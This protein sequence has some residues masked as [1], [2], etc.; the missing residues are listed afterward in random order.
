VKLLVDTDVLIDMALD[1]EP[2]A[3][4]AHCR[5]TDDHLCFT[6]ENSLADPSPIGPE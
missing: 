5:A 1:R 6:F 4:R 2:Y 3:A